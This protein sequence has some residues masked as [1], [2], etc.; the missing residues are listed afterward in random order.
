[1]IIMMMI[2]I[3]IIII[4]IIIII[5]IIMIIIIKKRTFSLKRKIRLSYI[6]KGVE[7]CLFFNVVVV[8][9]KIVIK[10]TD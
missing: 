3:I 7:H 10:L 2:I 8:L 9:K 1:M 4:M 6:N 5:I